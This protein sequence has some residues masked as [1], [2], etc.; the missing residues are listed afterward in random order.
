MCAPNF[1]AAVKASGL[2]L[3]PTP[4]PDAAGPDQAL[5]QELSTRRAHLGLSRFARYASERGDRARAINDARIEAFIAAV[6]TET[7][8]RR[9]NDLHRK[10]A[11]DLE[12][13][14]GSLQACPPAGAGSFLQAAPRNARTG[15][16]LCNS[17]RPMPSAIS[18]GTPGLT[19]SQPMPGGVPWRRERSSCVATRSMRP[20][21]R[22]SKPAFPLPIASLA[23]LVVP[24]NFKRILLR[25]YEM[26]AGDENVF[27]RDV[28]RSLIEIA[29]Q[30]VKVDSRRRDELAGLTGKLPAPTPGLTRKNKGALR[31]FDDPQ[32]RHRLVSLPVRVWAEVK[33]SPRHDRY[34]L[35]KAQVALAVAILCYMPVRS[36]NLATLAFDVHL[37][38]K[39]GRGAISSFELSASEVKN[40]M[41]MAFDIPPLLAKMLIEYRNVSHRR[42]S[43]KSPTTCSSTW[44]EPKGPVD[45]GSPDQP[46]SQEAG[47]H[48][49]VAASVSAWDREGDARSFARKLR[50]RAPVARSFQRRDHLRVLRR[51]RQ[52][53]RRASPSAS[54]RQ[55]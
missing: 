16:T 32:V 21:R 44:M 42:S 2:K 45:A 39:E 49:A 3:S 48:F 43:E 29:Y 14:R 47:K 31:Q 38:L 12:R 1:V 11:P 54:H 24:E 35:V 15:A 33:G 4:R 17:S 51:D 30:W 27:N 19:C 25:R 10:V 5:L 28:A 7:L 53:P 23:D 8:H 26:S 41:P 52:P 40:K 55:F 9:P 22:S 50:G 6:R 18:R 36:Q 46:P 34:T 13:G 37:F 20:S